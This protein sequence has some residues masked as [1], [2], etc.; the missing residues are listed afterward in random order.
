MPHLFTSCP[1]IRG[2]ATLRTIVL[3][4]IVVGM[5]WLVSSAS[6]ENICVRAGAGGNGSD[7]SNALPNVPNPPVRG[8]TYW[9]A[10]GT[11]DIPYSLWSVPGTATITFKKATIAEHGT[12]TGWSNSHG[13]GQ[14]ILNGGFYFISYAG[15]AFDGY[16]AHTNYG[17][18][19]NHHVPN[20]PNAT[21]NSACF[22][23]DNQLP[24]SNMSNMTIRYV[25]M[26]CYGYDGKP[27]D[28]LHYDWKYS[29]QAARGLTAIN[30]SG[31]AYNNITLSHCIIRGFE[32]CVFLNRSTGSLMEYCDLSYSS[33]AGGAHPNV[34][35]LDNMDN[36][37]FRY[38]R[39]HDYSV[40][41]LGFD[42]GGSTN[43]YIYGNLFYNTDGDAFH[44]YTLGN[45]KN[46][47]VYHNTFANMPYVFYGPSTVSGVAENNILYNVSS[48]G[49]WP[50]GMSHDY[51]WNGGSTIGPIEPHGV[52][53]GSANPFVNYSIQDFHILSKVGSTMP[54]N[55]GVALSGDYATDMDG[56]TRGSDSAWDI[57]AYEFVSNGS[58]TNPVISVS[59]TSMDFGAVSNGSTITKTITVRNIGGGTLAGAASVALPFTIV[60]G[61][62]Y[63]LGSNQ[64]S[65]VTFSYSPA[66][67]SDSQVATFT[68][69]GGATVT[70]NG[71]RL[72]FLPGNTTFESY[73]DTSL[74]PLLQTVAVT[75]RSLPDLLPLN[76][77]IW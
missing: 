46:V 17:F 73:A 52:K 21:F 49:N 14:A 18:R 57:G 25:E 77:A 69:G 53:G 24:N 64:S 28:Y 32:D 26:Q 66:S 10:D 50:S 47:N 33:S 3:A 38:N 5:L 39:V 62:S 4:S 29:I 54:R 48:G 45:F 31:R 36:F 65:V 16:S 15:Y 61:G 30:R 23:M 70:L 68:G 76:G 72:A 6:A 58:N 56:N 12:D 13:D 42:T 55:K 51:N 35:Y 19:I 60:S 74:P 41:G 22:Y 40:L 27:I 37:T 2:K 20:D 11:Y 7:W 8:N 71:Y 9:V 75:F 43:I 63:S 67:S 34:L 1:P 59:P 44:F